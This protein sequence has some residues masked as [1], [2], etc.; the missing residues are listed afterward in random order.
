LARRMR[1][2]EYLSIP[3]GQMYPLERPDETA[4][5]LKTLFARWNARSASRAHA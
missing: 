3:G 4:R 1:E 5:L 2:G